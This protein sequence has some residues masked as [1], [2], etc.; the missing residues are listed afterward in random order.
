MPLPLSKAL[1]LLAELQEFESMLRK[2]RQPLSLAQKQ[3]RSAIAADLHRWALERQR[4]RLSPQAEN[5]QHARADVRMRVQ[6]LG[7]PRP[8]DLES[9]SL[10]VGG[11]RVLVNFAPRVGDV[12]ALK[13]LPLEAPSIEAM[14][15][16][17]WY[18][19]R[20]GKA[21]LSFVD[22]DADSRAHLEQLIFSDL[23]SR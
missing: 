18:D 13:I 10:A 12:L 1:K 23:L 9:D 20:R 5:R 22:L 7:G 11:L 4:Q 8:I 2:R 15:R 17:V 21:G 14:A 19:P 3:R 16:V 6:M